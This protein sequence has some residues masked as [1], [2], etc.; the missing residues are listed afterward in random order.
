M[1]HFST[2]EL[3]ASETAKRLNIDNTP[4][5]EAT[6]NMTRLVNT[7]LDPAREKAGCPIKVNSGYRSKEL[8]K[9]VGGAQNSYHLTGRAADVTTGT[10][11]GNR[12][13]L[14]ILSRLP[15]TELIWEGN[16]KWIHVAL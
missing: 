15:H 2:E 9:A 8:N 13:L 14:A 10:I 3:T 7:V 16:G 1:K 5:D 11:I 12:R 4:D 6:V